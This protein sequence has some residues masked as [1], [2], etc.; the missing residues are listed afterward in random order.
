[1]VA[2]ARANTKTWLET[3]LRNSSLTKDDD[4]TQVSFI[5]CYDG[6]DY[7]MTKVFK[8]KGVDLIFLIGIPVS[9]PLPKHDGTPYGY[10][11]QVPIETACIDKTGLIGTKLMDKANKELRYIAETYPLGS[12][13]SVDEERPNVQ[14]LGST[15]IY[16]QK[17]TLNYRRDTS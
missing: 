10:E 5:I 13:R 3:Y 11:E 15:K 8:T 6:A 14:V 16:S 12:Q 7:P 1:M 9:R 4:S 17:F 2:D